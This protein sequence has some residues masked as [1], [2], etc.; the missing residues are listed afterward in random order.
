[1]GLRTTLVTIGCGLAALAASPAA[2]AEKWLKA[3]TRHFAI[4]SGGSRAQTEQFARRVEQ[5]DALMRLLTRTPADDGARRLPIYL[6]ATGENVAELAADKSKGIAGFYRPSRY[7]SF[8]VANRERADGKFDVSADAV[9]F[10]EYAHHFM[11]RNF[12]YAYPAWYIEGFAEFV[13]TAEFYDDGGW[14]VGKAPLFRAYGLV[15]GR[16][17]PIERVLFGT[18]AGMPLDLADIFYGRSWLLVH[19]L[20]ND[21]AREGQLQAYIQALGNGIPERE[22]AKAFG[23]LAVLDK[24]LDR[25]IG[26]KLT[27][28]RAKGPLAYAPEIATTELD[29]IDSRLVALSLRRKV[30]HD[31]A[32]TRDELRALAEAAPQRAPAWLELGL[33]EES[34]AAEATAPEAEKASR[35]AAE[36]A[37][38]QALVADPALGRAHLLKA[39]LMIERLDGANQ[40]SPVAWK[41]VRQHISAANR[42]DTED[43]APLFTWYE[44]IVRQ[45]YE[46][47]QLARDGLAKAFLL[48]PEA[49]DLRVEYAF[50]LARQQ[51]FDEALKLVEFVV[52]DPHNAERGNEVV[53]QLRKMRDARA[54]EADSGE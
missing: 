51:R 25:Y 48:A 6:L 38:D 2:A 9:L 44:S 50:D 36:A 5:F 22:A 4:Y 40:R 43:P 46:P 35:A 42:A 1:M 28:N 18:T 3:E 8:A 12:A 14:S 53:A 15:A 21:K 45:G 41:P 24:A 16:D 34:L 11:F 27:Y 17:L 13:S 54:K 7:G 20:R 19:M 33:A 47:D 37:V 10:H 49:V 39:R 26:T 52:R 23:D 32:R 30:G 31:L 29:P